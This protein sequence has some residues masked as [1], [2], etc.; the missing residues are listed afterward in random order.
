[1][2]THNE[3]SL[4][5][6]HT[7]TWPDPTIVGA[8]PFLQKPHTNLSVSSSRERESERMSKGVKETGGGG[9]RRDLSLPLIALNQGGGGG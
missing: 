9:V 8:D 1:M 7:H 3:F 2:I 6:A 5:L 4:S